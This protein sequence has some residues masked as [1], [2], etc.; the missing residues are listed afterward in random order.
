MPERAHPPRRSRC[1]IKSARIFPVF[2]VRIVFGGRWGSAYTRVFECVYGC[3]CAAV[4]MFS[5]RVQAA[6]I[7]RFVMKSWFSD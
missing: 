6:V 2:I 4:C 5:L 1:R 7:E 3:V